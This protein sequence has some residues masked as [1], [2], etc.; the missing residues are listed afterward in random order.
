MIQEFIDRFMANRADLRARF[1]E[2][3]PDE[4]KTIVR[5]VVEAISGDKYDDI[6]PERIHEIDDGN[7]QGTL[8]F[9]IAAKGYQPSDYWTVKVWYGSCSGCDTLESISGY[10]D[11][12]PTEEQI[13]DYMTL[14]L[15]VVQNIRLVGG[16]GA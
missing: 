7:Y 10:S 16:E 2:S 1:A 12:K 4:Y 15:H 6:D 13:N 14:A 5:G 3:H 9:V 8:L 11:E